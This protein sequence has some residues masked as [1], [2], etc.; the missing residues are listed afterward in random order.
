MF[1]VSERTITAAWIEGMR[2]LQ[3]ADCDAF[4]AILHVQFPAEASGPDSRARTL[5]DAALQRSDEHSTQTVANTLFPVR[6]SAGQ[7]VESLTARYVTQVL[8]RIR[9]MA[10]NAHGTYFDRLIRH[11]GVT[12]DGKVFE[13]NPLADSIAKMRAQLETRGPKRA[14]YELAIYRPSLDSKVTMGFPCLSHVSVKL[15]TH[16]RVVHLSAVY[17]NQD[18]FVRAYGNL[19][20]LFR[21]QAFIAREL[22]LGVGELVCH[23]THA[24]LGVAQSTSRRLLAAMSAA[25]AVAP[26]PD[27]AAAIAANADTV[28][29]ARGDW[30]NAG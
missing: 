28:Y 22:G 10:G 25:L 27:T 26:I 24:Q 8:P 9:H 11:T 14:A 19:L 13:Q 1:V 4:T 6:L 20:G 29:S 12:R 15:D 21:L 3:D 5:L 2:R 18:Y 17:R 7:T 23:A 16:H 30:P